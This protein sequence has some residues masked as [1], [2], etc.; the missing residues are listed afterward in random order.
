MQLSLSYKVYKSFILRLAINGSF[1]KTE[2]SFTYS[3]VAIEK[4]VLRKLNRK[5]EG[6][7]LSSLIP[8]MNLHKRTNR[9]VPVK[10]S[11]E[12]R[13]DLWNIYIRSEYLIVPPCKIS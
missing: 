11:T 12:S 6:E 3:E 2:F 8:N 5:Q 7:N 9:R 1:T 10:V 13:F 4:R